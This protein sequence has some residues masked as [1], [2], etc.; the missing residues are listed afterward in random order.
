MG[1]YLRSHLE[2]PPT[3]RSGERIS[4]RLTCVNRGSGTLKRTYELA[5]V[6]GEGTFDF[7]TP[8]GAR[9]VRRPSTINLWIKEHQEA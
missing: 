3:C 6:P 1:G 7:L 5:P 8:D 4:V 9:M 2:L